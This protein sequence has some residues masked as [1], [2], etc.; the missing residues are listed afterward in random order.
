M[1]KKKQIL[2]PEQKEQK[3]IKKAEWRANR[4]PE[5]VAEDKARHKIASARCLANRTPEKVEEH[6]ARQ[7]IYG[8]QYH[9]ENKIEANKASREWKKN[10]PGYVSPCVTKNPNYYK[11]YSKEWKE[12]NPGYHKQRHLDSDLG[13][14]AVYIIEDYMGTGDAYCG[15]TGNL[16]TRMSTHRRDGRLN[17]EAYRILQCFETREQ[18]MAFEAIQHE[19]GYHGYNNGI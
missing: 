14:Y 1:A 15:Q 8:A 13:Y 11:E 7:K 2:T 18:A 12:A 6:K 10:N 17:T 9:Q 5:K 4:S 19:A 3:K 16:Y